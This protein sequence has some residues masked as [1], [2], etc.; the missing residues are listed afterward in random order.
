[1]SKFTKRESV[2]KITAKGF[3]RTIFAGTRQFGPV[4]EIFHRMVKGEVMTHFW[5]CDLVEEATE[6]GHAKRGMTS[7]L[8]H[9]GRDEEPGE[10]TLIFKPKSGDCV[11]LTLDEDLMELARCRATVMFEEIRADVAMAEREERLP[12]VVAPKDRIMVSDETVVDL[13]AK[14]AARFGKERK[15][16]QADFER[17]EA[18]RKLAE[19]R[20]AAVA[21]ER[22]ERIKRE[23]DD[24][25][26][27]ELNRKIHAANC[28][29]CVRDTNGLWRDVFFADG[30]L[31]PALVIFDFEERGTRHKVVVPVRTL[32]KVF[33][34]GRV[35][36][37]HV[38]ITYRERMGGA[39]SIKARPL[40][41]AGKKVRSEGFSL[42]PIDVEA[43]DS[44][45]GACKAKIKAD[46]KP[47]P[48]PKPKAKQ[49]PPPPAK[50]IERPRRTVPR[51]EP[52]P[53]P[54]RQ[55]TLEE[56]K[57][58]QLAEGRRMAGL[59]S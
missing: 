25:A 8:F 49:P 39:V 37:E 50:K 58:D 59:N 26:K 51:S 46:A 15:V 45:V 35:A 42:M 27:R 56:R 33:S 18:A 4:I 36:T 5:R 38:V 12:P 22:D 11:R 16:R 23:R 2:G 53:V 30:H 14:F 10:F 6:R 54:H 55:M 24:N 44:I 3:S 29:A 13:K 34:S 47:A 17:E 31:G 19:E 9:R 28:D 48:A 41:A 57:A 7:V 21:L 1:M 52:A 43:L 40:M 20:E 32:G